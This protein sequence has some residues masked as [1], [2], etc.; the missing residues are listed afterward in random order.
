[1]KN[2]SAGTSLINKDI[3]V[4]VTQELMSLKKQ[5]QVLEEKIAKREEQTRKLMTIQNRFQ[6]LA[7]DVA[8]KKLIFEGLKD[9]LKEKI[10]SAGSL[11]LS[12]QLY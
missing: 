9:Q 12:N 6:E 1:M 4:I 5:I 10:L 3:A 2:L 8:K 7:I 11:T